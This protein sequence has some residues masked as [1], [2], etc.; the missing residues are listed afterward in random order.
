[1]KCPSPSLLQA[2]AYLVL[3]G[4]TAILREA[5]GILYGLEKFHH[6]C[7]ACEVHVLKDHKP[8]VALMGN[9]VASLSQCL[10]CIILHIH[11]Y[12]VCIL[13]KQGLKL[14]T[15][16]WLTQDNHE[17]NKDRE[18]QSLS[19]TVNTIDTT[20]DLQV[21]TSILRRLTSISTACMWNRLYQ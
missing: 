8:L 6:Y 11:W 18:I 19:I 12:R 21:C 4:N 1:M 10:Q 5:L 3:S 16:D 17:E 7:F 15:V 2:R 9:D 20:L 14:C 13:Y